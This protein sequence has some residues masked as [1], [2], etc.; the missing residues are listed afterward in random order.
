M[1]RFIFRMYSFHAQFISQKFCFNNMNTEQHCCSIKPILHNIFR[2]L[3]NKHT[4]INRI[5]ISNNC[6]GPQI[7]QITA[8]A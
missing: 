5:L 1:P 4:T 7:Y 2:F 6:G 3:A 8:L